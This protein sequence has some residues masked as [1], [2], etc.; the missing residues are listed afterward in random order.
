VNRAFLIKRVLQYLSAV[1]A[2]ITMNFFLI[3]MMPGDPL[4]GLIGE[5]N[6]YYLLSYDPAALEDARLDYGLGEPLGLQYVGYLKDLVRGNLGW[7]FQYERPVLQVIWFRLRW[8]LILLLPAVG[9]SVLLGGTLGAV[10]GWRSGEK[11]DLALTGFLL[12]AYSIPGYC[13]GVLLLLLLALHVP[14]F[15]MGGMMEGTHSGFSTVFDLMEHMTLPLITLVATGT[16]GHYLVMRSSIRRLIGEDFV[17]TAL[18]KGLSDHRVLFRHVVPNALP[19]LITTAAIEFGFMVGGVLLVETVFSWQ[20]M[21]TLIQDAIHTRD[22]PMLSGCLLLLT[23]CLISA[24]ALA[25]F[26][27]A[28]IDP[29]I[30]AG[31]ADAWVL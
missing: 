25:D 6:Y 20:G 24:N 7:T 31:A 23:L 11:T 12:F 26:A 22:Y 1:L 4:A 28:A 3:R 18:A 27:H 19:P 30:R 17:Y 13:L 8:T 5:E 10:A 9:M 15:P 29:G 14:V 2:V 21:G 16:T